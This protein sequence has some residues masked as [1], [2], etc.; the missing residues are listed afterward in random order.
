MNQYKNQKK[1]NVKS[2]KEHIN[3]LNHLKIIGNSVM[4][5]IR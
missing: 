1:W 2:V 5:K 3:N 4:V